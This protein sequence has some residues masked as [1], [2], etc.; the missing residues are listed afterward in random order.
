MTAGNPNSFMG[1]KIELENEEEVGD[2]NC[3][4]ETTNPDYI[5][6]GAEDF[7]IYLLYCDGGSKFTVVTSAQLDE[8]YKHAKTEQQETGKVNKIA[9]HDLQQ[10]LYIVATVCGV[11]IMTIDVDRKKLTPMKN[12]YFTKY[13]V[14]A[15]VQVGQDQFLLGFGHTRTERQ[16]PQS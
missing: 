11:C 13:N 4:C 1:S 12:L 14:T 7:C 15:V 10:N 3:L 5:V 6:A 8:F 9:K 16:D 2:I